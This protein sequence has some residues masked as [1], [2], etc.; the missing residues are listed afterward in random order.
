MELELIH[1]MHKESKATKQKRAM[2]TI[3][4]LTWFGLYIG[5]SSE[6]ENL[7]VVAVGVVV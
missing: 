6:S 5:V 1:T 3:I 2:N 4:K 7:F